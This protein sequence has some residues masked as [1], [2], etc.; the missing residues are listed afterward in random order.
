MFESAEELAWLQALLDRSRERAGPH[1]LSIAHDG[2]HLSAAQVVS[3]LGAGAVH[4]LAV[5]TVTADGRPMVSMVDGHFVKARLGFSSDGSSTKM[6]HLAVRP[7]VSAV[8]ARGDDFAFTVHGSASIHRP[9]D[10]Q[11]TLFDQ[12]FQSHYG[13]G[14]ADWSDDPVIA[15]IEP[16]FALAY[17]SDPSRWPDA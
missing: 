8:H 15:I 5:A 7:Q 9:G 14:P 2:R 13:S 17:A 10:E 16:T 3:A 1:L 11:F 12:V 4:H 6:R